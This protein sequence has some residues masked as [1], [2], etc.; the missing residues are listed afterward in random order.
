MGLKYESYYY[1]IFN[2]FN[3]IFIVVFIVIVRFHLTNTI[4]ITMEVSII[5]SLF[6]LLY[7]YYHSMRKKLLT[8]IGQK[9]HE[10]FYYIHY[11]IYVHII[12]TYN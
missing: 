1:K 11:V 10:S 9:G 3:I 7:S 4:K 5:L 6:N 12:V 8:A 2:I